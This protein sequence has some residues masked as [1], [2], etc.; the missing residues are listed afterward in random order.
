[1]RTSP[2][3]R[4]TWREQQL[5]VGHVEQWR[6]WCV[7][8]VEPIQK[9]HPLHTPLLNDRMAFKTIQTVR[10]I[11]MLHLVSTTNYQTMSLSTKLSNYKQRSQ[12]YRQLTT[13]HSDCMWRNESNTKTYSKA[14]F[15][16]LSTPFLIMDG[17]V[18]PN[19]VL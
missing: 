15:L 19:L 14:E 10:L 3:W 2:P 18:L 7:L 9:A 16:S 4:L 11:K 12:S 17:T 13:P 6:W 5:F 1:M 8:R